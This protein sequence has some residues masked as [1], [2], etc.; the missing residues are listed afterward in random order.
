[1]RIA[2]VTD[3]W[4]PQVNGVVRTLC[5]TVDELTRRGVEVE[6]VTP[7]RFH[8][9]PLPGYSAIRVALPGPGRVPAILKACAPRI[10]H[11]ATEGPLG[12]IARAWCL[13]NR[14]PFT[15]AFHTRFPDYLALRTRVDAERFWPLMR[16]FHAP[17]RAVLVSTST[18]AAELEQRGFRNIRPWGRGIDRA[19]FHPRH[20]PHPRLAGLP[21]PIQLY[22]GRIAVEKNLDEFLS[23]PAPGSKVVV[24]GG[25]ALNDLR[26][27]YPDAH[28]PGEMAGGELA[29]AYCAAD[30]FVF[31]SRTET[32]GLVMIEALACGLPVAGFPA[33]AGMEIL[34]SDGRGGSGMRLAAPV[35]ALDHSLEQAIAR[36]VTMD[37]QCSADYGATFSWARST[38]Q[39]MA[40][41]GEAMAS[42]RP[43]PRGMAHA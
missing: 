9:I 15:S 23:C 25:P 8:T 34:G 40:A 38:D 39:F 33:P 29:S 28:F 18:L 6:L 13:R 31:P 42:A 24:G 20:D 30:C 22:V 2:L 3:A 27:R 14:V 32:F 41:L 10:V 43:A 19:V 26:R 5:A 12:W 11:I 17:S 1:M 21:R 37:R 7:Q 4:L 16:R 36:A 35:G